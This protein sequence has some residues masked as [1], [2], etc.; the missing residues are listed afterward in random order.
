MQSPT[1]APD[2][3]TISKANR[4][5]IQSAC[6]KDRSKHRQE[7]YPDCVRRQLAA[8]QASPDA[9]DLSAI[10]TADQ[11]MLESA[12]S[13]DRYLNGPAA[14]YNCLRRQLAALQASPGAPDLRGIASANQGMIESACGSD[15]Y[16]RGP[17][18]YYDCMRRQV[19]ALQA[20]AGPPDLTTVSEADQ[21]RL[22]S[23]CSTDRSAHGPA[24][25]YDC[26]RQQLAAPAS[27]SDL[28]P[29]LAAEPRETASNLQQPAPQAAPATHRGRKV[30]QQKRLSARVS[31]RHAQPARAQA[32]PKAPTDTAPKPASQLGPSPSH[33]GDLIAGLVVLLVGAALAGVLHK[34]AKKKCVLCGRPV[35]ATRTYCP[36]CFDVVA[37]AAMREAE[38]QAMPEEERRARVPQQIAKSDNGGFDPYVVLGI[39]RDASVEEIRA[40]YR[41]EIVSCHPD[42]VAHLGD[43]FQE[44]AK[45]K[46]QEINRA[47]AVLEQSQ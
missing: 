41:R 17:A 15:R 21:R 24:A 18:A 34:R 33:T 23:A 32:V 43:E 47:Y 14:Y 8:L 2:L 9:P 30:R 25:Y 39:K 3:S 46:A 7:A 11:R 20:S 40:A 6:G 5:M 36:I 29:G 35:A 37:E 4:E 38:E 12:C 26:L 31:H 1:G 44:L 13:G 22:A 10:S 45:T 16:M 42:K 19:A 27:S 28:S